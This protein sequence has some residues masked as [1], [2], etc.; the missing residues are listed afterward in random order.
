MGKF[1]KTA[2]HLGIASKF[3]I[4]FL[5]R[6]SP[7]FTSKLKGPTLSKVDKAKEQEQLRKGFLK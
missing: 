2:G 3:K 7:F 6:Y 4:K 5:D 1:F